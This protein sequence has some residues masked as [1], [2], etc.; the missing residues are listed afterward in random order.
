MFMDVSVWPTWPSIF[1]F[2]EK[3]EVE[4]NGEILLLLF[5]EYGNN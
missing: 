4:T 2:H 1:A 3:F 5:S